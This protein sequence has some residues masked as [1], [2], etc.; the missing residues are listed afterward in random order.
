MSGDKQV[1]VA[2]LIAIVILFAFFAAVLTNPQPAVPVFPLWVL[3]EDHEIPDP[4]M[5]NSFGRTYSLFVGGQNLMG[6]TEYCTLAVKLRNMSFLL[7]FS[8]NSSTPAKASSLPS[9]MKFTFTLRNNQTWETA[10]NF[11][12]RGNLTES[13]ITIDSVVINGASYNVD[14][15][16]FLDADAGPYFQFFFEL[17]LQDEQHESS[18][19]SGVWAS[20]PLLE[21]G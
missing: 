21:M 4:T 19:F 1:L 14:M 12:I 20:S 18:Y 11:R 2:I 15:K 9:V 13:S 3:G 17:W 16:S 5:E 7:P 10:F 6:K 8:G